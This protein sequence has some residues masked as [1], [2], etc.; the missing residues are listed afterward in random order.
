VNI[1]GRSIV[2]TG[3]ARGI[4]LQTAR[5]LLARGAKVTITATSEE[6]LTEARERLGSADRLATAASDLATPDGCRT[7]VA[8]ALDAFGF[9]DGLF[10]NAGLYAEASVDEMTE[11]LWDRIIDTNLKS[12]FF[13]IQ[14]ALPSLREARGAI[15]TMSSYN[16]VDG[17]RGNV[18]AY[19][20]AKAG[21]INMT[22]A[23]ALDLAP[24]VRVNAIAP[25]FVETEKL[26]AISDAEAVIEMLGRMTAVGRIAQGAEI[27]HAVVFALEN[28]FLTGATINI[29]GGRC[30]GR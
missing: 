15:V 28:E 25:G 21:V 23:L 20:A 12:A 7:A 9:V 16:G 8:G 11:E 29:D 2:V 4:G 1:E 18:S 27:A 6:S 5:E 19:G 30:A 22:R 10:T 24:E 26:L 17:V 3:G 13:T 14:A